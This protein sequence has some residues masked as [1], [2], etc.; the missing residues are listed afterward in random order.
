MFLPETWGTALST[1]VRLA[2]I[3]P[4]YIPDHTARIAVALD[5]GVER[6]VGDPFA[7]APSA[8]DPAADIPN[9]PF[10]R[11]KLRRG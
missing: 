5:G 1:N 2:V 8:P 10:L 11:V 3:T 6:L 9:P 4:R 7:I